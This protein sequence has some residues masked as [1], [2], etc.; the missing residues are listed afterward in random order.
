[1][2]K[3]TVAEQVGDAETVALLRELGVDQAQGYHLGR[4]AP[5]GDWLRVASR[6]ARSG[7]TA[8]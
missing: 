1:M 3:R 6:P 7:A 4:P 8:H 2:G 5:L